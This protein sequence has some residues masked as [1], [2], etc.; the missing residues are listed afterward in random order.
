MPDLVDHA[1]IKQPEG[2]SHAADTF[3]VVPFT[4]SV[5]I[6]RDTAQALVPERVAV[7]L[8]RVRAT[9]WIEVAPPQDLEIRAEFDG[10]SKVSVDI[11]EHFSATVV[12]ARSYPPAP[13]PKPLEI[14]PQEVPW[15]TAPQLYEQRWLFHGP[16]F[17]A[18]TDVGPMGNKG[19]HGVVASLPARG[20]LLDAS[21]QLAGYWCS[22]HATKDREALP[23]R[24]DRIA[25]YGPHPEVGAEIEC[26]VH[27]LEFTDQWVRFDI[28][29]HRDGRVWVRI[30]GWEDRRFESGP[31]MH[32]ALK[33]PHNNL[34]AERDPD[35]F[36]TVHE[37]WRSA[38][39]RY[40]IARR[41]L[42]WE[43]FE[44]YS[45]KTPR[46]QRSWLLGRIAL[47]DAVRGWLWD[48][49]YGDLYPIEI[50]VH[51]EAGGRPQ[52]S[53]PFS[54][55]LRVSVAQKPGMGV[56]MVAEG[57]DLGIDI[58]TVEPRDDEFVRTAFAD[59]ELAL[60]PAADRDEWLTRL[61]VAKE[62]VGKLRGSGLGGRPRDL[63][64]TRIEGERLR[65]DGVW[66]QTRRDDG[67]VIGWTMDESAADVAPG[68]ESKRRRQG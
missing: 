8:E 23:F 44:Q 27:V 14:G 12:M 13:A 62:A 16:R 25:F 60:L 32:R 37:G 7:G 54:E 33:F 11:G 41:W 50:A 49:G 53:G 67:H 9:R 65:V 1:F 57:R 30:E 56:A 4:L 47:K 38:A 15:V 55:D 39:S 31:E 59:A 46:D 36:F 18:V 40:F 19:L 35:G 43:E 5:E 63:V 6:V 21:G 29:M 61:W 10:H 22:A 2:W 58:E 42:D 48:H 45:G 20:S 68:I 64:L 28:D 34:Y 3:P 26:D 52:V 66:V 51:H 24:V 17:H